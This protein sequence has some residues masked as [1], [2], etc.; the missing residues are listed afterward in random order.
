LF[1]GPVFW[2]PRLLAEWLAEL[3][4][5]GDLEGVDAEKSAMELGAAGFYSSDAVAVCPRP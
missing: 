3:C 1:P 4:T 2:V 5:V